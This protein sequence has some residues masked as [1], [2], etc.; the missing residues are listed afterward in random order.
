[1]G[2]VR[3]L[4]RA[5]G[6]ELPVAVDNA[7]FTVL[8]FFTPRGKPVIGQEARYLASDA[9]AEAEGRE[10]RVRRV[11][12]IVE[13]HGWGGSRTAEALR[14]FLGKRST[15]PRGACRIARAGPAEGGP[16]RGARRVRRVGRRDIRRKR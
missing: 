3:R 9:R 10:A 14:E 12:E 2:A 4:K 7:L 8:M 6:G 15:A 11:L 13:A 16:L 1:V 5:D